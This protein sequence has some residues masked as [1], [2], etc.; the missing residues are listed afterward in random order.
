MIKYE[1]KCRGCD[2]QFE[3]WFADS[4]AYDDQAAAGVIE[5]PFCMGSDVGKAIMAPN[6]AVRR[7][8]A[9][10]PMSEARMKAEIRRMVLEVRRHVESNCDYVGDAFAAE[11]R[12]MHYGETDKRGIY[13]E[14]TPDEAH[15]LQEE[16]IDVVAIPWVR[17]DA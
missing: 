4:A 10:A 7:R 14:T 17:D 6:I 5:C 12:K 1:L 11:A 8:D 2:H 3:G 16:G 9:A 13:G 15:E